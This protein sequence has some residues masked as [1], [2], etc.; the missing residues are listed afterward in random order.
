MKRYLFLVIIFCMTETMNAQNPLLGRYNTPHG[1]VPFDKIQIADYE[2]AIKEGIRIHEKEIA[3]II[4][5]KAKPSFV[6]T[7]VALDNSGRLIER[8]SGVFENMF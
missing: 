5:N 4:N 3:A 6:N 1:T 8:V 7:I 2:P